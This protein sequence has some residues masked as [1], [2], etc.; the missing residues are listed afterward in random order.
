MKHTFVIKLE[1]IFLKFKQ[2]LLQLGSHCIQC[3]DLM[4]YLRNLVVYECLRR[5]AEL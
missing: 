5:Q 3:L 1:L 4:G 2:I